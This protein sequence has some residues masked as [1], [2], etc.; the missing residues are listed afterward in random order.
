MGYSI[1][2]LSKVKCENPTQE[3]M[4]TANYRYRK[5]LINNFGMY[6]IDEE[7][8]PIILTDIQPWYY[9]SNYG[10]IYSKLYDCII[11]DRLIGHGYKIVTLRTIYNNPIDCLI[12]RIEMITFNPIPN[13]KDMQVNHKD[14]NKLNN[15]LYNLEWCTCLENI[16][17]AIINNIYN[18]I[19]ENNVC[20]VFT[21]EQ[22]HII[23]KCLEMN[24][25]FKA[26]CNILN[27]E[28]N[29]KTISR[30]NQIKRHKNWKQ[31]SSQY[32]F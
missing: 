32:K 28:Y 1:M 30:I 27:I 21:N 8:L 9:V 15:R 13:Y 18:N 19:G 17:H 7:W 20:A 3:H 22:V 11:R 4:Q 10:R 23:C 12:H 29:D 31:I 25:S 2:A 16:H 6:H 14:G 26:I 5:N 24:Y